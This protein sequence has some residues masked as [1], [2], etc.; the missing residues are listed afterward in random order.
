[1][2]AP[3]P[4]PRP[5]AA[6]RRVGVR[7]A[8]VALLAAALMPTFSRLVQPAGLSDGAAICQA[9]PSTAGSGAPQGEPQDHGDACA[10]CTL[11][12]TTPVLGG[13]ALPAVALL[14]YAPPA[15]P[16]VAAWHSRATQS[17]AP[18]AR[19]PPSAA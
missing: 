5:T 11:V 10:F 15:P 13:S 12:H 19:A 8:F 1:M 17:R 18:G 2:R 4:I 9:T 6:L 16:V 14:A 3:M 7:L